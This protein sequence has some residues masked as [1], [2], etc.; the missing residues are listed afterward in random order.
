M[1]KSQIS[2]DKIT[3]PIQL[4]GAWLV[5]LLTIDSAFLV[6]AIRMDAS[7]WQSC[8]LTVAAIV[9]VPMFICALFLLQT[10]FR[11]EL[12]EDSFY[13]TYLSNRTN[14][15]IKIPRC[16]ALINELEKRLD[17]IERVSSE[18]STKNGDIST[19]SKFSY[20]VNVQLNN[21]ENIL[22]ALK[23]HGVLGVREFG[24]GARPP[25]QLKVAVTESIS[26]NELS[27]ILKLAQSLGFTHYGFLEPFEKI[28]E[29][30]LFGAYGQDR[31]L[32]T[33]A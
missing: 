27:E 7:S 21:K 29:D 26:K 25:K 2:P 20:G 4:L 14:E 11:P 9:N 23:S 15:P 33:V 22:S 18:E 24:Q 31:R 32:I 17:A 10:K 1:E 3:K 12:Q 19:I 8:A 16:E 6:A 13:S 5:G 28:E 30:V